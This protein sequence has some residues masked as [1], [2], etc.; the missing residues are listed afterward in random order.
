MLL[1]SV[2]LCKIAKVTLHGGNTALND[3]ARYAMSCL[4][5]QRLLHVQATPGLDWNLAVTDAAT[6]TEMHGVVGQ[7]W[8][9][10]P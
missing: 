2:L 10:C 8:A 5:L 7:T 4:G 6:V 9:N 1:F 3:K